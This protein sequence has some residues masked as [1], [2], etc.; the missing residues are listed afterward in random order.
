MAIA[1]G[2]LKASQIDWEVGGGGGYELE[3]KIF[4]LFGLSV[5]RGK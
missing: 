1:V 2:H 4:V 5:L 3:R